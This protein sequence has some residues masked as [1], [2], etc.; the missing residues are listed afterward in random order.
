MLKVALPLNLLRSADFLQHQIH[1]PKNRVDW[2]FF[3]GP[4]TLQIKFW[5][6]A[7][8][9]RGSMRSFQPAVSGSNFEPV[10]SLFSINSSPPMRTSVL[11]LC[12]ERSADVERGELGFV[13]VLQL[14]RSKKED[15][16]QLL[17]CYLKKI[18]IR[19]SN[20]SWLPS[21]CVSKSFCLAAKNIAR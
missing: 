10:F 7:T 15:D 2:L 4:S 17:N 21:S 9:L 3:K 18:F 20:I 8:R 6:W 14:S 11:R 1:V 13:T 19:L 16:W 12:N 5:S